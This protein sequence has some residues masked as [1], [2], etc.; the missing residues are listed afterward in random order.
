MY[1]ILKNNKVQLL[2]LSII[3]LLILLGSGKTNRVMARGETYEKLSVFAEVLEKI[4]NLYVE[5]VKPEELISG[6][7][8]G[9]FRTLDPH[10]SFLPPDYYR[11]IQIDTEG[12]FGGLGI[13]ITIKDD[14]LTVISPIE[15]TPA[16]KAGIKAGDRII[17]VNGEP[18]RDMTL[19][20][21]VKK[22]RGP[23]GTSV[24]ITIMRDG[25]ESLQDYT[26]A[27]EIIKIKSVKYKTIDDLGYIRISSFKKT[28]D[29]DLDKALWDLKEKGVT[30]LILDLRSNPGG[31]LDQ[32]V[33]VSGKF[34]DK[35]KLIVYTKGRTEEQNME[36]VTKEEKNDLPLIVL[37]NAG[38]A[39]ASEIVAGAL[40]DHKRALI[41]GT[42]T[43][44][45]GSV[46]VVIPLSDGSALRL[47]TARYYTPKGRIIQEKGIIPDIIVEN[48]PMI[49]EDPLSK[50][51]INII[52]EKDLKRHLK[53]KEEEDIKI[54]SGDQKIED[55]ESPEERDSLGIKGDNQ[56]ER[57]V[58]ILKGVKI[59]QENMRSLKEKNS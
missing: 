17:K 41:L 28:T 3:L 45:K 44:G 29:Q 47:T 4:E 31:L 22:M 53:G 15:D 43:F 56:L 34:L 49:K 14:I 16:F 50:T 52:R 38:S 20:E 12:E 55:D 23:T 30:G 6:A 2:L 40:Q 24:V 18:T 46:Q 59:F 13:E 42:Q 1:K 51:K 8:N 25:L 36:F 33:S 35:G 11:E 26:I 32:A 37:T 10:S 39:S 19:M 5:E 54:D 7:I 21:A 58:S 27:R 48:E 9:M 57:A